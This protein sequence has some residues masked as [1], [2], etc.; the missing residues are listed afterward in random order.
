MSFGGGTLFAQAPPR[1]ILVVCT[2]RIGD[3]LLATPLV[4]SMK[5]RWPDT[6]IDMLVFHG[7]EGVLENNPDIRTVVTVKQRAGFLERASDMMRLWRRYDLACA[8][9]GSDRSLIYTWMAGR[10]R[11]GVVNADHVTM[12]ARWTLDKIA[13]DHHLEMHTVSSMLALAP[14]IGVVPLGEVVAPSI[15]DDP[16][17]R[18]CFEARFN[19]PPAAHPEQPLVVLHPSPMF[20]YKQWNVDGW[21]DTILWLHNRGYAIALSGGPGS[22]EHGYAALITATAK[23]PVLNCVG[24]LTFAETAE[25]FRRAVLYIG[26]DTGATHVAAA[27]GVPTIA[28]FGPTDPVR[29]APWPYHWPAGEE[30][31]SR[32]G[33]AMRGNVYL[34]QGE[35]HC[36]PCRGEGCDG[37]PGSSSRCLTQLPSQRVIRAAAKLLGV[38]VSNTVITIKQ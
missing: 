8:V 32:H 13:L 6:P 5:R 12:L 24:K 28:L 4:R 19:A 27:C 23:V 2:R 30:P 16:G 10:K 20:T 3:V 1:E 7:T 11:I 29:W 9:N 35:A 17:R 18:K 36:V 26:P 15:G 31:W 21:A 14:L 37:H 34:L 25:M 38:P 22:D 33:S